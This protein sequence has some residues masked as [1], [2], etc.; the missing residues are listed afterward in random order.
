MPCKLG[1]N[2][3]SEMGGEYAGPG[4]AKL[5]YKILLELR[6]D[7]FVGND[8]GP[9]IRVQ[10]SDKK[11]ERFEEEGAEIINEMF[12]NDEDYTHIGCVG[13]KNL[14]QCYTCPYFQ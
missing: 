7:G 1:L 8:K 14:D 11:R 12:L 10:S 6:E 3:S 4:I 13:P 5:V 9:F 2:N